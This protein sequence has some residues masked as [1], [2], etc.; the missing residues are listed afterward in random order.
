MQEIIRPILSI[1]GPG[2]RAQFTEA[3]LMS[4][5]EVARNIRTE[6]SSFTKRFEGHWF[7]C[8]D[9]SSAFYQR[10][11]NAPAQE[12]LC[13]YRTQ[14]TS[15]G[16]QLLVITHQ[17]DDLQHR[18]V[19]PLWASRTTEFVRAIDQGLAGF[20]F[21]N[22]GSEEAALLGDTP[23]R[24]FAQ[25]VL[26]GYQ[27]PTAAQAAALS[28]GMPETLQLFGEPTAVPSLIAGRAVIEVSL[29]ALVEGITPAVS[30]AVKHPLH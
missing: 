18:F 11:L 23:L 27:P 25:E 22:N 30:T 10:L 16:A 19:L 2:Y 26:A 9:C 17:V 24:N 8:G 7:V 28:Q 14:R 3:R 15:D 20:S 4:P 13:E 21:G 6:G 1:T 29:S 5:S 12:V